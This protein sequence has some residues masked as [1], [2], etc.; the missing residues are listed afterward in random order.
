MGLYQCLKVY[1][2]QLLRQKS[3]GRHDLHARLDQ[4][5]F[6]FAPLLQVFYIIS[7]ILS[8]FLCVLQVHFDL[9]PYSEIL[10]QP[11]LSAAISFVGTVLLAVAVILLERKPLLTMAKGV[12]GYW[13]FVMSWI[14]INTVMLLKP[15]TEWKAIPHTCRIRLTELQK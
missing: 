13:L 8:G 10:Y 14:P 15:Q 6:L 12:L 4:L 9:A 7:V 1:A 5:L 3:R 11:L 2:P